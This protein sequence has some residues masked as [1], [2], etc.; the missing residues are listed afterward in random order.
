VSPQLPQTPDQIPDPDQVVPIQVAFTVSETAIWLGY[1][2]D[3]T[4]GRARENAE[5]R[6]RLHIRNGELRARGTRIKLISGGAIREFLAHDDGPVK[7]RSTA[8]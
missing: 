7:H 5:A 4:I 1:M 3:R 8:R 2:N 6:V